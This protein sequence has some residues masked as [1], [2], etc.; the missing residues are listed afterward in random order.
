MF[1][2][3]TILGHF[4]AARRLSSSI[5]T[6]DELLRHQERSMASFRRDVL[7]RSPFYARF[8]DA[9]LSDFPVMD[10][11]AM[12]R[13]FDRINTVGIGLENAIDVAR[14]A[15]ISRDFSP[16]IG[17]VTVGLSSGTSG[18]R[19]V[20]LVSPHERRKWAGIML[21]KA[22]PRS[23]LRPHRIAFFLRANSN[24]YS[25][26]NRGGHLALD[27]YDLTKPIDAHLDAL[28][29]AGADVLTAPAS[30]LK[31][32]AEL[33]V[34]GKVKLSPLRIYS[35]AEVLEDEDAT[36]IETA[37]GVAPHQIYQATEGFLGISGRDG[38][39]VLNEEY[40]HVEKEWIDRDA[41]KFVPIITDF[42]RVSQPIVRYRLDDVLVEDRTA[43][44]PFTVLK[45]VEGRCDDSCQLLGP[46]GPVTV[47]ADAIRQA[48]A[49]SGLDYD[50]YR[51]IQH[52]AGEFEAQF[53]PELGGAGRSHF[54]AVMDA[55]AG[56]HGAASPDIGFTCF[57]PRQLD[58]KFR[59]IVRIP[60]SARGDAR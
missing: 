9:P 33:A 42:S 34:E 53:S 46:S 39:I 55:L 57:T 27:F 51:L 4:L 15:E 28:N 1:E 58:A 12:L 40:L 26:L 25:T 17:D 2:T 10:K 23:I 8:A 36:L 11:A 14:R 16:S 44:G 6:R 47:F 30:V 59:R 29:A 48:I 18:R 54:S 37:F 41:G 24:L 13:S 49:S 31:R 45:A 5:A 7:S 22:L 56:R 32:L 3:L 50:D 43:S 52:E 60:R 35:A 19:G 38:R 20:F 21:A